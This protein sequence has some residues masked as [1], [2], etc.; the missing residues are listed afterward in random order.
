MESEHPNLTI[1]ETIY[2]ITFINL[3]VLY[4]EI[5]TETTCTGVSGLSSPFVLTLLMAMITSMPDETLPNTGCWE[6]L[7]LSNQSKKL[8]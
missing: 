4:A 3:T 1:Y 7:D 6:G 2:F 5:V 8:L